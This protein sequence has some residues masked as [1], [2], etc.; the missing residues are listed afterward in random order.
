MSAYRT[1]YP[2]DPKH[3]DIIKGCL[4]VFEEVFGKPDL[5]GLLGY[6]MQSPDA[7]PKETHAALDGLKNHI[8]DCMYKE[9]CKDW[10]KKYGILSPSEHITDR[11]YKEVCKDIA[12]KKGAA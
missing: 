7:F 12:K 4:K 5:V 10:H 1:Y 2:K 6:Y 9:V 3:N 8:A 11:I